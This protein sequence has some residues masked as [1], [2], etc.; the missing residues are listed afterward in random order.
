MSWGRTVE[1][2]N[3]LSEPFAD[4]ALRNSIVETVANLDRTSVADLMGLL[5]K[6]SPKAIRPAWH[7][8]IQ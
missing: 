5:V 4:A 7:P 3:W 2:F 6:V 1:K 8:D